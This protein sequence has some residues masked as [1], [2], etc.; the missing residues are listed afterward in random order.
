MRGGSINYFAMLGVVLFCT[1]WTSTAQAQ[2]VTFSTLE[3]KMQE[4]EKPIVVFLHTNWCNYCA[5]MEK[6]TF[7]NTAVQEALKDNVYFVSF[8]A[9]S[10]EKIQF[11]GNVFEYRKKGLQ[12][13][14]HELAEALTSQNAYPALV[15]LNKNYEIIYQ[16]Y[17]YVGPKEM[18]QLLK[19]L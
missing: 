15:I 16:H 14:V 3:K 18:L 12:S 6:K 9:E 11:K 4:Q 7:S 8:D 17:A 19:A 5:L 2:E 1:I 10:K 13:G